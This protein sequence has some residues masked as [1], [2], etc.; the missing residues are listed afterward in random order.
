PMQERRHLGVLSLRRQ[1][2]RPSPFP[3]TTLFRSAVEERVPQECQQEQHGRREH[4]PAENGLALHKR[5]E[6]AQPERPLGRRCQRESVFRDRKS[7]R[8]NS[9]HVKISYAV[10]RLKKKNNP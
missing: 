10:V 4:E 6:P 2:R 9:S 5:A 1:P 7:T 3:Y 8:L